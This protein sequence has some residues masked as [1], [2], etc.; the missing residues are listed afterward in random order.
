MKLQINFFVKILFLVSSS[1]AFVFLIM[2]IHSFIKLTIEEREIS[3]FKLDVINILQKLVNSEE[4]LTYTFNETPQK[5][6]IDLNKLVLF[7]SQ[8]GDIEPTCAKALDFDYSV[9]VVQLS[10][11]VKT[12]S[13]TIKE[14]R[15]REECYHRG[16][17]CK[18]I[19]Y[20]V[21]EEVEKKVPGHEADIEEKSWSFGLPMESF[22]PYKARSNELVLSLPVGIR[23]NETFTADGVI[24]IHAVKGELERFYSLVEYI[25][26]IA[27]FKP[28]KDVKVSRHFSFSFPV[29]IIDDRVCMVNSCKKLVCSIPIISKEFGEGEYVI[30]FVYNSTTRTINIY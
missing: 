30:N 19:C 4:C 8:Y 26:E 3:D 5:G 7:T 27:E 12:Y 14:K 28:T 29:K 22:S 1:I 20:T 21:C 25:C 10:R 18:I 13:T 16:Y 17:A 11:K 9:K 15:C 23:Y 24:Y 2:S 6:I